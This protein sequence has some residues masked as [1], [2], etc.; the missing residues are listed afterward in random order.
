R[1]RPAATGKKVCVST[2]RSDRLGKYRLEERLG[3][4]GMAEVWRATLVGAHGFER[5]LAVKRIREHLAE[6]PEF[7][8]MFLAEARLTAQL[9]HPNIVQIVE[10]GHEGGEYFLAMELVRGHDLQK[11]ARWRAKSE[12]R[13]PGFAAYVV[14]EIARA[15]A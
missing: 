1:T 2:P 3:R 5:Q 12:R 7:V 8:Q 13:D 11:V 15:L 14:L 6:D 9:H 10:L 4:G